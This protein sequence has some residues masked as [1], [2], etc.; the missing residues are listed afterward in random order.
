M[1]NKLK[2]KKNN[3]ILHLTETERGFLINRIKDDLS[4]GNIENQLLE[5]YYNSNVRYYSLKDISDIA[6]NIKEE[7]G[8]HVDSDTSTGNFTIIKLLSEKGV[9]VTDGV[10]HNSGKEMLTINVENKDYIKYFNSPGEV[11]VYLSN[12]YSKFM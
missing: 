11:H 1:K 2:L 10:D 6:V 8:R 12:L 4:I 7:V 3:C 5:F 9:Y